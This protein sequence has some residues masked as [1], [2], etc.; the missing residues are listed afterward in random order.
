MASKKKREKLQR[1]RSANHEMVKDSL[2]N[3][4]LGKKQAS[5]TFIHKQLDSIAGELH[6]ASR[7]NRNQGL[8][9][10]IAVY[11][12]GLACFFVKKD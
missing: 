11:L 12:A 8:R 9:G 10:L 2:K 5:K 1:D 6:K 3:E 4:L 7:S